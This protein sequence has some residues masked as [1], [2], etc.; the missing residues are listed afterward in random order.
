[1]TAT[2]ID[3]RVESFPATIGKYAVFERVGAGTMGVVYRCRQPGLNRPV[4]IKVLTGG[5]HATPEHLLRFQ[6]EAQAAGKIVHPNV[7]QVHDV[8]VDGDAHY[9]VMEYVEGCSLSQLIG[10]SALSLG[11]A[12]RIAAD[13]AR[14]LE[15]AHSSGVVH[16]DLKPSNIL[17][18]EAGA[19]KLTDFGL[20][21]PLNELTN[22][23]QSGDLIGTPRYMAPEQVI[24]APEEV[25]ERTDIYSLGA[26]LYEMLA[27][28]PV[29]ED[30]TVIGVLRRLTD[31]EPPPLRSLNPEVPDGVAHICHKALAKEK[32]VRY[33]RAGEMANALE[34]SL[35]E[36]QRRPIVSHR[37]QGR[38]RR[39]L[40]AVVALAFVASGLA[41]T[42]Y[43]RRDGPARL[44]EAG[45]SGRTGD[46]IVSAANE[47][48]ASV[49]VACEHLIATAGA[50]LAAT[51]SGPSQRERLHLALEDV[52]SALRLA[53]ANGAARLLRARILRRGGEFLSAAEDASFVIGLDPKSATPRLERLL[54]RYS[55]EVLYL[56]R[57]TEP[58][59]RPRIA[60]SIRED[61]NTLLK[62]GDASLKYVA[63]LVESLA[64]EDF[65]GAV[66]MIESDRYS[67]VAAELVPDARM[68]EADAF[69]RWHE[70]LQ[71]E[72]AH[73]KQTA[74]QQEIR[75][76]RVEARRRGS[77]ALIEGLEA[78][79]SHVGLLFLRASAIPL[80]PADAFDPDETEV[81]RPSRPTLE[82]AFGR[83]RQC[84]MRI[85]CD[86]SVGLAVLLASVRK[87]REA[88]EY[89]LDALSCSSTSP[90]LPPLKAWL[91]LRTV[92]G[93]RIDR[94][95]ARE[96]LAELEGATAHDSRPCGS[97]FFL[98]AILKTA[99]G[100][101]KEAREDLNRFNRATES[102]PPRLSSPQQ[103]VWL[104]EACCGYT[105]RYLN[106]TMDLLWSLPVEPEVRILAGLELLERLRDPQLLQQESMSQEEAPYFA[107]WTHFRLAQAYASLAA[108]DKVLFHVKSA[109]G[110]QIPGLEAFVF[111]EDLSVRDWNHDPEFIQL[112]SESHNRW[113]QR[114]PLRSWS[115]SKESADEL[116]PG[117]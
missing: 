8:G 77:E 65:A 32:S 87:E 5:G 34:A 100:D 104:R 54:A 76:R 63:A 46:L 10:S 45:A 78:D 93:G 28:R 62:T 53:P 13:V 91:D 35:Q 60:D 55:L 99:A 97:T 39:S 4:A 44:P 84:T 49:E 79:P 19:A 47:D 15:A 57:L 37:G 18:N 95:F 86:T 98:M 83:L 64:S 89:I 68:L 94:Q 85:G 22:L 30:S 71:E 51:G 69:F 20:A 74:I 92:S 110:Y 107:G 105:S 103:V 27:G 58:F 102:S 108:R 67:S 70:R 36:S 42:T 6:K 61:V 116:S 7:V 66:R 12:L 75:A 109:L 96:S 106:S 26:V 80:Q 52:T 1:M 17:I 40:A 3:S 113:R 16:R 38:S 11:V 56:G 2:P 25:D 21:K 33:Q 114:A 73:E 88:L 43:V 48:A 23:S 101:W 112:Y 14:A 50:R 90:Y 81:F 9:F 111:E 31:D 117:G 82:A 29:V 41:L 115:D 72:E 24:G 59:L